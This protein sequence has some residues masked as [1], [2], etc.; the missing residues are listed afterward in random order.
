MHYLHVSLSV[1]CANEFTFTQLYTVIYS[2]FTIIFS[3]PVFFLNF[4]NFLNFNLFIKK[5]SILWCCHTCN[6][7][8]RDLATFGYR[9]AMKVENY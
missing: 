7:P 5:L 1:R 9:P 6:H 8:R 2:L 3:T 4:L